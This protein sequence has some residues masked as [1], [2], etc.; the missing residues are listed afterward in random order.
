VYRITWLRSRF[1]YGLYYK[2]KKISRELYEWLL[3]NK[4]ASANLIAKW[5]KPGHE[6]LCSVQAIDQ[7]TTN[8]KT[9]SI[10]RVPKKMLADSEKVFACN[11]TG[12]RGCVT[13]D[14]RRFIQRRLV[15]EMEGKEWD[16]EDVDLKWGAPI[17]F[18][19]PLRVL[20]YHS[21]VGAI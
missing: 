18:F 3:E 12:C 5:K 13:G 21:P 9:N 7:T 17:C 15:A 14:V 16:E 8:F 6:Y 19:A 4:Y 20:D 10:C 1:V 2:K 11:S